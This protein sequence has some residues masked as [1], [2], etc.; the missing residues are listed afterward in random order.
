MTRTESRYMDKE[1][2]NGSQA[3]SIAFDFAS[4]HMYGH[5]T[6]GF[7]LRGENGRTYNFVLKSDELSIL[8]FRSGCIFRFRFE[9]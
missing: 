7:E 2:L 1:W 6:I 3:L 4:K 9:F 5:T 8:F